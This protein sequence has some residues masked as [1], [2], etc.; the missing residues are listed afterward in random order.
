MR[1][2]TTTKKITEKAVFLVHLDGGKTVSVQANNLK[3][4]IKQAKELVK[5]D[6]PVEKG[7]IK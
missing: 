5:V 2:T 3:E 7:T 1:E 4:A 6:K